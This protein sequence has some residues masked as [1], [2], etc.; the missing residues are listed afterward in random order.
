MEWKEG[1]QGNSFITSDGSL[2]VYRTLSD[3]KWWL[4]GLG[5]IRLLAATDADAA[6][7]EAVEI[8]RKLCQDILADLEE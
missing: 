6:K 5:R 8:V 4:S 1:W 7:A 2:I 3:P